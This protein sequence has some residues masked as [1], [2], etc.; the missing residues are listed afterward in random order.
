MD[1]RLPM[2]IA[3]EGG[4]RVR[5]WLPHWPELSVSGTS[6][7]ELRDDLA[8]LVMER[9]EKTRPAQAF[10]YQHAPHLAL[11]HVKVDRVA[12]DRDLGL[13]YTLKGRVAVLVEKWPGE[14]F[15][16]AT[17]TRLPQAQFALA[18]PAELDLA[19][20]L[21]LEAWCL[22][23]RVESLAEWSVERNE[24]LDLL[25]V[26]ADAPT[27]LPRGVPRPRRRKPARK[28]KK[29]ASAERPAEEAEDLEQRRNRRRLT[30][31]TLRA[32]AQN[33]AHQA[34]DERLPRAFGR[35]G[36]VRSLLEALGGRDGAAVVLV[37]G[38]GVG[39]TALVHEV[40]C[41][42]VA[43][44]R[45]AGTRRDVWRM[46]GN[47]FIAGMSYVGQWEARARELCQELVETSDI[48]YV[49]DL[50]ALVYAGRTGK[51]QT[52]VGQ[53]LEPYLARRE[54]TVV[55]ECSP[56]RF[57][58][59]REEAPSLAALFDV[60]QVPPLST[61]DTL[62]VLLGVVRE[63]E[64]QTGLG[65]GAL[66]P[67]VSPAVQELLLELSG[68]FSAHQALPGRAVQLLHRVL[69]ERGTVLRRERRYRVSDVFA[70]ARRQTGLPDFVLGAEA[71]RKRE[72]I[73]ADLSAQVAGQ[74][75]AIGAV[76][77]AVLSLQLSLQDPTKP[78]A[79]YLF[80]GPT[81]VGKTETAK[82][83]A[84][85]LFGSAERLV[86]IDMSELASPDALRR[87]VG[88]AGG[89]DGELT[90][91][92][93]TQPFC[94]VLLD[95]VEKAH[96][97][98]FDALLQFLGEGRLT[99]ARGHTAD[100]RNA[101]VIM[102]SNVGVREAASRTGFM[103]GDA[104]AAAQHY[105]SAARAFFRPEL[106]NRLD[107]VVPFRS[108]GEDALK[109]VVEHAL[110]DLLSRRGV[111]RGNV[112]VE[113]EPELLDLLVT[114][115]YDPRYGARPLKRA[116]ERHLAV[117]L[118]HHLLRRGAEDLALVEL[119]RG[120]QEL[121]LS[122][123][124][125]RRAPAVAVPS[126][127]EKTVAQL[128][129]L[130]A[131]AVERLRE[132]VDGAQAA[133]LRK[134][135]NRLLARGALRGAES[136][137]TLLD[138]LD[139]LGAQLTELQETELEP[140][141]FE[142]EED[143]PVRRVKAARKAPPR[144]MA[145]VR[146]VEV[147]V[148][149][150]A[151]VRRVAPALQ[152][153]LAELVMLEVEVPASAEAPQSV[154]LLIEP[155]GAANRQ[156]LEVVVKAVPVELLGGVKVEEP[157]APRATGSSVP[158]AVFLFEGA[159]AGQLLAAWNGYALVDTVDG[160]GVLRRGLVRLTALVAP[161]GGA[162]AAVAAYDARK[163]QEREARRSRGLGAGEEEPPVVL[164][165]VGREGVARFVASGLLASE[166]RIHLAAWLAE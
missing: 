154:V 141:R 63:L 116:L 21:A 165:S 104:S 11:R 32:V 110:A 155:I 27:V 107:R 38:S 153:L 138:R 19:L 53:Y 26:D 45:E 90:C 136:A 9:L 123:R 96:P 5:A 117:P 145:G 69:S 147:R 164:E 146:G 132:L 57:E 6:L 102:T 135:R 163:R 47:Q 137:L 121:Q 97:R 1:L 80:V 71:P 92:L 22:R 99:D 149:G 152:Q 157:E 133:A 144:P 25:E 85:Y 28:G 115:A 37:G 108:L 3:R 112:L 58:K 43:Q 13:R 113:V 77:D 89:P 55:A 101:V 94:V 140:V 54:L 159:G 48:L 34:R 166:P 2:V 50:A 49:D 15:W 74:P 105:V 36:L 79:N 162:V 17:P 131:E 95:E 134:E 114:Q 76:A 60:V 84:R 61:A 44:Q 139:A 68:R 127:A 31:R 42:L 73:V 78:L 151:I 59:V 124:I 4:R 119:L 122:V 24:E 93:R 40:T 16:I 12:F 156:A 33:L 14:P 51:S 111:R 75:E 29:G 72:E 67:R 87:L 83:L 143:G 8:L 120:A 129:A 142:E 7:S 30:V 82:A 126:F 128:G 62:P 100:G 18:D 130:A 106:F 23:H 81:G 158:R 109:V 35:E 20:S 103:Q 125:L 161:P 66:R 148:S 91:A 46:D 41:R 98:V 88:E 118:A 56:E 65:P 39:K 10:R 150:E 52:H 160:L 64:A 86:R 70:A